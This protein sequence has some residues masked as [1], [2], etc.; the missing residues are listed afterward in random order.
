MAVRSDRMEAPLLQLPSFLGSLALHALHALHAGGPHLQARVVRHDQAHRCLKLLLRHGV[1]RAHQRLLMG[2][3]RG[4]PRR[5][6]E[7]WEGGQGERGGGETSSVAV[8]VWAP[9]A[10]SIRPGGACSPGQG[11]TFSARLTGLQSAAAAL[12]ASRMQ[13][14]TSSMYLMST[15]N[16]GGG[17]ASGRAG[18]DAPMG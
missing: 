15:C 16:R 18:Q 3:A 13:A 4:A 10:S 9:A 14:D 12:R 7:G 5:G 1:Q 6:G 17:G 11:P 8:G 2:G